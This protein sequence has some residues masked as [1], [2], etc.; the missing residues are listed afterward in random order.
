MSLTFLVIRADWSAQVAVGM[1]LWRANGP[2]REP[3]ILF[4]GR[5]RRWRGERE[6]LGRVSGNGQAWDLEDP[7]VEERW[8]DELG[9]HTRHRLELVIPTQPESVGALFWVETEPAG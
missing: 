2:V 1:D 3:R 6:R 7:G 8:H 4:Y 9:F 5:P